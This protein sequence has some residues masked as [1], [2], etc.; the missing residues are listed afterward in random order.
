MRVCVVYLIQARKVDTKTTCYRK[1][2]GKIRKLVLFA[3]GEHSLQSRPEERHREQPED[4]LV[5]QTGWNHAQ[6]QSR[7]GV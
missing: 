2:T 3:D 6:R 5:V 7:G 1:T 4:G